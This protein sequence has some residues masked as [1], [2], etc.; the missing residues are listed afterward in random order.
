[1][2]WAV[3][4]GAGMV[5]FVA[6]T[7]TPT[8]ASAARGGRSNN[9]FFAVNKRTDSSSSEIIQSTVTLPQEGEVFSSE[10][11][12]LKLLPVRNKVMRQLEKELL[13]VSVIRTSGKYAQD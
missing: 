1:M 5:G 4:V 10:E 9:G 11:C 2:D 3:S 13:D 6:V 8:M 12:L 7:T